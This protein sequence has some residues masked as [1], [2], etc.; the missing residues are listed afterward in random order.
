MN[1]CIV[2]GIG[3]IYANEALFLSKINPKHKA[4]KI[5]KLRYEKLVFSMKTILS[6]AIKKGGTT[7]RDFVNS[8][9]KPGY[10]SNELKVYNS[11]IFLRPDGFYDTYQ[12]IFLVPFAEYV[13]FFKDGLNIKV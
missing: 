2:V 4:S 3:N 5:S 9:G 1:H 8:D 7:I 13:R 12:K 11:A 10:F 6:K